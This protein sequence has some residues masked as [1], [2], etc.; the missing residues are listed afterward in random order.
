MR[1]FVILVMVCM[2]F[3]SMASANTLEERAQ[4]SRDAIKEFIAEL[5]GELMKSMSKEGP[6]ESIPLCREKAPEIA[7]S[8]S[9]EKGWTIGRTTLK[10]R[11]TANAP[12]WWEFK[13]L[14]K[15]EEQRKKG[16]GVSTL[17]HYEITDR[18]GEKVFRYIKAIPIMQKPC[19]M[20][21]GVTLPKDV[22]D[23]MDKNYPYDNATGYNAGEIRGAFTIIQPLE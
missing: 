9:K 21:H 22:K 15:F 4:A 19:L 11:N 2:L 18:G 16:K 1:L 8:I 6:A 20:C 12:D 10:L 7:A 17:E 3:T 5:K 13:Y 14:L 23:A